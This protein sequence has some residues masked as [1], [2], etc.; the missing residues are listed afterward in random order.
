MPRTPETILET[1]GDIGK[2]NG[3]AK[4]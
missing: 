3:Y 1:L 4:T 2:D